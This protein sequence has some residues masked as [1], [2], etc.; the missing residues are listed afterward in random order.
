MKKNKKSKNIFLN[1][2]LPNIML[3][4]SFLKIPILKNKKSLWKKK[5]LNNITIM[6]LTMNQSIFIMKMKNTIIK[7]ML[8]KNMIMENTIIKNMIMENMMNTMD[9]IMQQLRKMMEH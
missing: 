1:S 6:I 7:K 9:T 4:D 5:S 8:I 2:N 3:I